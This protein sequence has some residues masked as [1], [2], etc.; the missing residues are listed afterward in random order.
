MIILK[1]ARTANKRAVTEIIRIIIIHA[2]FSTV[3]VTY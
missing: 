2:C 3:N 1:R